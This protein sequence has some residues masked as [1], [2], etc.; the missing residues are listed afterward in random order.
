MW[1]N[2]IRDAREIKDIETLREYGQYCPYR[3]E[4]IR[5][6]ELGKIAYDLG[7]FEEA[8][9]LLTLANKLSKGRTLKFL[10]NEYREFLLTKVN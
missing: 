3:H 10:D 5:C 2:L 7:E 9:K 8:L 6:E 1:L 4:E